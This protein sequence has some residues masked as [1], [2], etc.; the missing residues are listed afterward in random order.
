MRSR[1]GVREASGWPV[2]ET[3]RR[4]QR[5][6]RHAHAGAGRRPVHMPRL[7]TLYTL[8]VMSHR[9]GWWGVKWNLSKSPS[10]CPG[11]IKGRPNRIESYTA[12]P[13]AHQP[14]DAVSDRGPHPL[15][16]PARWLDSG[17]KTA[18]SRVPER[19]CGEAAQV[20]WGCGQCQCWTRAAG[21]VLGWLCVEDARGLWRLGPTA[22]VVLG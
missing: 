19:A 17:G 1:T 13:N 16:N 9:K 2:R 20:E 22:T 21:I 4:G 7:H 11:E 8:L 15:A 6:R 12:R 14:A 10:G 5:Q 3:D 18:V